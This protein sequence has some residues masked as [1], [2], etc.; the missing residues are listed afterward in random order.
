MDIQG[1]DIVIPD[2]FTSLPQANLQ[3]A[4]PANRG[5]VT[6]LAAD[7]TQRPRTIKAVKGLRQ[8]L[9]SRHLTPEGILSAYCASKLPTLA[10][11]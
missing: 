9:R 8:H 3:G 4:G 7:A 10:P 11:I 1:S 2:C 5:L 6:E